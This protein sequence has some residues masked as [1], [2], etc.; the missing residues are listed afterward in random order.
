[1]N[2]KHL[3]RESPWNT[4]L[5]LPRVTDNARLT[6]LQILLGGLSLVLSRVHPAFAKTRFLATRRLAMRLTRGLE[7]NDPTKAH[8]CSEDLK[9]AL[10]ECER[11]LDPGT[12]IVLKKLLARTIRDEIEYANFDR[13]IDFTY[14]DFMAE[15]KITGMFAGAE[16]T[17]ATVQGATLN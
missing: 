6:E 10:A 1:M 2:S 9:T 5:M 4:D 17:Q 7:Y 16:Q 15:E 8:V 3:H 14:S 11:S 12:L 13:Q